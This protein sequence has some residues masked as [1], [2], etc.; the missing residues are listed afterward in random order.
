VGQ[1]DYSSRG[2]LPAGYTLQQNYPNP[3]N[4]ETVICCWLPE[5]GQEGFLTIYNLKGERVRQQALD[6]HNSGW[7]QIKWDGKDQSNRSVPAG[8]YFAKMAGGANVI[9]MILAR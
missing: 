2:S 3:F 4:Q 5:N 9:K 1:D 6:H 8:I 7:A